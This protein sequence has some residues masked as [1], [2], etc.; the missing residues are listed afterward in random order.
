VAAVGGPCGGGALVAGPKPFCI[1]AYES[2]G[3]GLAPRTGVSRDDAQAACAARG[4]RL[5]TDKEWE[6][7]CRGTN[8]SSYP[9]GTTYNATKCNTRES[10]IQPGGAFPA[11]RSA[12]GAFDMSG[13]AAE[14]TAEGVKGGAAG[15]GDPAGR[16]SHKEHGDGKAAPTIGFRCCFDV[17]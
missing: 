8:G 6:R 3:R 11:C 5:C 13:N 7:A 4:A 17:K 12:A 1:D 2:P 9:Y 14:W 10:A 15:E 16:C